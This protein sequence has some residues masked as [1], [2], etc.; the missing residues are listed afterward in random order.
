MAPSSPEFTGCKGTA[1]TEV[2]AESCDLTEVGADLADSYSTDRDNF[3]LVYGT[4]LQSITLG[5]ITADEEDV[6]ITGLEKRTD[7]IVIK[8]TTL[9]TFEDTVGI[10]Y[11]E[12]LLFKAS[13]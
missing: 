2:L 4:N 12:T 13:Y 11:K 8:F 5:D 6:T 7:H 3:A 9:P 1:E 10:S